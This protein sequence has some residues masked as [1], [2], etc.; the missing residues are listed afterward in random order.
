MLQSIDAGHRVDER[1]GV[2]SCTFESGKGSLRKFRFVMNEDYTG[3]HG[4][5]LRCVVQ[6]EKQ[7]IARRKPRS[8]EREI[9]HFLSHRVAQN[10]ETQGA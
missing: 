4:G 5:T 3:G 1:N 9:S 6:E 7:S 8:G 10:G 2:V